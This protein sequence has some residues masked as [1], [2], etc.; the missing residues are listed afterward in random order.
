[1]VDAQPGGGGG[2]MRPDADDRR[3]LPASDVPGPSDEP[4]KTLSNCE[5]S[6]Y[7]RC[8]KLLVQYAIKYYGPSF[9]KDVVNTSTGKLLYQ[10][11]TFLRHIYKYD[12]HNSIV[13]IHVS[14]V[15]SKRSTLHASFCVSGCSCTQ[16]WVWTTFSIKTQVC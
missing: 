2:V 5:S 16:M 12:Y 1:M 14:D 8:A 6:S 3:R 10:C 11:D 9:I 15:G 7:L 13:L 4:R